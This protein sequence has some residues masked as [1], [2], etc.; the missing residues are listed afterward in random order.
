MI[1][2]RR[3]LAGLA[4]VMKIRLS[5]FRLASIGP[6]FDRVLAQDPIVTPNAFL[7]SHL[8]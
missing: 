3:L 4:I 1:I 8:T 7:Q 2:R 6:Q 5:S